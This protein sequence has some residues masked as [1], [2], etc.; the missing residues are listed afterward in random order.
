MKRFFTSLREHA[1]NTIDFEKKKM[2]PINKRR[3]KI[4][5]RCKNKCCIRCYICRKR[6]L[7][8]SKDINY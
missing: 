6:I 3:M 8:N 2:L 4:I 1:K 7:N 5:S